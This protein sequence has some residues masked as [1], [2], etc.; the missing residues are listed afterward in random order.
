MI[1]IGIVEDN[2]FLLKSYRDFLNSTEG[3]IVSFSCSSMEEAKILLDSKE[4]NKPDIILLDIFLPGELG[5]EGIKFFKSHYPDVKIIM[6]T[7]YNESSLILECLKLGASGYAIKNSHLGNLID[8][9]NQT[10]RSGAYI[11]EMAAAKLIATI[12]KN[13]SFS[14]KNLLTSRESE[15]VELVK[16]GF[17]YKKMAETLFV[18]TYTINY[19]LKN[20]YKKL[21]IHSKS[22]LLSKIMNETKGN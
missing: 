14:F 16:K 11:D 20:V 4:L 3:I 19:H 21:G 17:S 10:L 7:S 6:L 2:I 8:I 5:T 12:H 9:I 18:T 15:I 22:A 1:K 13:E